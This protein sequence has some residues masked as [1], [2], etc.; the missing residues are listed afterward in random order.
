MCDCLERESERS[1]DL[2]MMC[3]RGDKA[4]HNSEDCIDVGALA[5]VVQNRLDGV[6]YCG[7]RS[8]TSLKEMVR[9]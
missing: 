3:K 4:P 8:E 5:P 7:K 9:P 2:D 1:Y 6:R